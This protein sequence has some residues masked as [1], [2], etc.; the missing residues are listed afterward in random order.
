MRVYG[1]TDFEND[2]NEYSAMIFTDPKKFKNIMTRYPRVRGKFMVW[3]QYYKK[4]DP[5]FTER[6]LLGGR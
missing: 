3:L 6:Y 4:I 5:I 1:E 2:F